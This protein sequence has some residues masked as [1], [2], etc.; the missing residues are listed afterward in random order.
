MEIRPLAVS[1]I[2]R[3][4][5]EILANAYITDKTFCPRTHPDYKKFIK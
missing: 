3:Q 5:Y 1:I 2:I 4:A